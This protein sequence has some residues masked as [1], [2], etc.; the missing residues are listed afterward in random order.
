MK[1]QKNNLLIFIC[2]YLFVSTSINGQV[3]PNQDFI[4]ALPEN[5]RGDFLK[6]LSRTYKN[7]PDKV[8]K[9]PDSAITKMDAQLQ[10]LKLQIQQIEMQYQN[11]TSENLLRPFGSNFFNTYQSTFMPINEPNFAADYILMLG[12]Q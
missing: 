3:A 11:A 5:I 9:A 8:F 1:S 6:E 7:E 2:S 12:I 4:G 10:D